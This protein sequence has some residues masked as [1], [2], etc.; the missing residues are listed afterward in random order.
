MIETEGT[1]EET[2]QSIAP[3]TPPGNLTLVDDV[4]SEASGKQFITVVTKNN[5]YFYLVI[6]RDKDGGE[7]VHFLNMVDESDLLS[8][9]EEDEARA[10]RERQEL[11]SSIAAS[12]SA[13]AAERTT[14]APTESTPPP[15]TAP[16][17]QPQPAGNPAY[18][19]AFAG[20]I[21]LVV[22]LILLLL[23]RGGM[24]GGKKASPGRIPEDWEDDDGEDYEDGYDEEDGPEEE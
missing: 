15:T 11:E 5:N 3:L 10:Y 12:L 9:L 13:A 23:L 14:V 21:A 24:N 7:N 18:F 8:L 22:V 16:Q 1:S 4:G 6:D 17:A 19:L 20:L 2:T